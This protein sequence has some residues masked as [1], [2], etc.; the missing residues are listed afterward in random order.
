MS[1]CFET[2]MVGVVRLITSEVFPQQNE[3]IG[4]KGGDWVGRPEMEMQSGA[5]S[6]AGLL[7]V[8]SFS[9]SDLRV[10]LAQCSQ[11]RS[12]IA[13]RFASLCTIRIL[14]AHPAL[15]SLSESGGALFVFPLY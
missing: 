13:R 9:H 6:S 15:C 4:L 1:Y 10:Q 8:V 3:R 14:P 5:W 12:H 11:E 7:Q 2:V